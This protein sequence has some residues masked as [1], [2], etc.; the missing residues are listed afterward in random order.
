MAGD[1]LAVVLGANVKR[2]RVAAGLTME[3]AA[4]AARAV[5]GGAWTAPRWA[6]LEGG[7]RSLTLATMLT[8]HEVVAAPAG[9]PLTALF[10]DL[11]GEPVRV[12]TGAGSRE[13]SGIRAVLSGSVTDP[14]R[15]GP[16]D[17][18]EQA[19]ADSARAATRA[20]ARRLGITPAQVTR[21]AHERWGR[22]FAEVVDDAAGG[23]TGQARGHVTRRLADEL[24]DHLG[25]TG[26][27]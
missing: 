1:G 9:L 20:A 14:T 21:A 19:P 3:D 10:A 13:L 15:Q 16:A 22:P 6:D 11:P 5:D 23:R 27:D 12:A 26:E 7:R 24:A 2:L 25:I 17:A 8:A 18:V 4:L